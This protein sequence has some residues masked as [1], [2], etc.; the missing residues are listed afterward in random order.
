MVR[1]IHPESL[2]PANNRSLS[3]LALGHVIRPPDSR[4]SDDDCHSIPL[5]F[6][7][8]ERRI[9]L[10][11][12]V[13]FDIPPLVLFMTFHV[14]NTHLSMAKLCYLQLMFVRILVCKWLSGTML[15]DWPLAIK[16]DNRNDM[17]TPVTDI[18]RD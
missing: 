12:I 5:C 14:S 9:V 13:P 7:S 3:T 4:E 18:P 16:R 8:T 17:S 6:L 11:S 1:I 2:S 15:R 10:L